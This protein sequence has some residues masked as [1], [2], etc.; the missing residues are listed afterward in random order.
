MRG[1]DIYTQS[2][3]CSL[4]FF[5]EEVEKERIS[6]VFNFCSILLGRL[7]TRDLIQTAVL[8]RQWASGILSKK[9]DLIK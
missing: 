4:F 8:R 5:F 9:V 7:F 1:T 6:I 3:G 2:I